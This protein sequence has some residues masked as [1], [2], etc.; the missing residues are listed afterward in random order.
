MNHYKQENKGKFINKEV[1]GYLEKLLIDIDEED[2]KVLPK[3]RVNCMDLLNQQIRA[4]LVS[5]H[6]K[7][8]DWGKDYLDYHKGK[9]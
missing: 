5:Y 6:V 7:R 2:R 4:V 1:A 3:W 9:N 8:F